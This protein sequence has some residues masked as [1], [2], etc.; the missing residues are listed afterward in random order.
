MRRCCAGCCVLLTV[1]AGWS[2]S[3]PPSVEWALA[4]ALKPEEGKAARELSQQWLAQEFV[5]KLPVSL[6]K[7]LVAHRGFH[8]PK[9]SPERPIEGTLPAFQAAWSAGLE[10]CECDARL[11][12]DRE[13]VLLHDEDLQKVAPPSSSELSA[14]G[15]TAAELLAAPLLQDT[16]LALLKDA[17]VAAKEASAARARKLVLELKSV[18]GLGVAVADFFAAH[19]ELLPH[20]AVVMSFSLEQVSEFA[21]RFA[22]TL[23]EQPRPSVLLLTTDGPTGVH[24]PASNGLVYIGLDLSEKE[25]W[26]KEVDSWLGRSEAL[27]GKPLDGLYIHYDERMTSELAE[28]FR[29]LCQRCR[30]GVWQRQGQLDSLKEMQSLVDLGASFVNTDLPKSFFE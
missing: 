8:C 15:S 28:M 23:P 11:T 16:R 27:G 7:H 24:P 20:V 17:L 2:Q 3:G 6:L 14:A 26:P 22:E 18:Q 5:P 13:I 9:I 1:L 12:K 19:Q 4:M 21:G 10:L 30:V 29:A 25:T